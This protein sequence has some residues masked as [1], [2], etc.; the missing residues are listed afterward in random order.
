MCDFKPEL[1]SQEQ[2]LEGENSLIAQKFRRQASK[3]K[4]MMIM[5]YDYTGV[6]ATY[7]VPYGCTVDQHAYI[8]FLH[9]ILRLK[10]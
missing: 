2:G 1:K 7:V 5:G 6:I 3:E 9:K 4:Q 8:H 10:I